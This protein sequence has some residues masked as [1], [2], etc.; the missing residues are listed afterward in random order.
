MTTAND[1][2]HIEAVA[3]RWREI[4]SNGELQRKIDA[5]NRQVIPIKVEHTKRLNAVIKSPRSM[6]SKIESVWAALDEIGKAIKP[7]AACKRGCSHCCY[8]SVLISAR[9]AELIGKRIG[10]KPRS[11]TGVRKRD[12]IESGYHNPCPFLKDNACS[13]YAHRPTPCRQLYNL[14]RDA[15]LCELTGTNKVPYANLR[16]YDQVLMAVTSERRQIVE[17]DPVR[18]VMRPGM[19]TTVP[20]LGDIRDFFPRGK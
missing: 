17:R 16:D 12:D 11:Y 10:V 14:D 7:F 4:E 8:Q 9:E 19:Q 3:E 5:M 20:P 15:L 1:T 2:A 18:G 6:H 13:I